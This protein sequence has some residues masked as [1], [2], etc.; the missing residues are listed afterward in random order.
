M[1]GMK[2]VEE[3]GFGGLAILFMCVAVTYCLLLV[4]FKPFD[5]N[6]GIAWF[7]IIFGTIDLIVYFLFI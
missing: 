7:G 3:I 1:L 5:Y 2:I 6:W 4:M